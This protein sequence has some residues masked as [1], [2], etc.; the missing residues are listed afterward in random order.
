MSD[1]MMQRTDQARFEQ[2][3]PFYVTSKLNAEDKAF[4]ES[5]SANNPEARKAIQFTEQLRHIVRNTGT[6]RNPNAALNRLLA[7]YKPRQRMSLI[8]RLLAKLRSLGISPPLAIAL[9]VI[10]GQGIGYAAHKMNWFGGASES[11]VSPAEAQLSV[12]IK[13]GADYGSLAVIIEKF[14]GRI[15]HSS[16]S[17]DVEKFFINV[18]DK[19]KI[20]GLIDALMDAGLIDTAAI[21]L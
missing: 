19:T 5:Y 18:I 8:K 7:D 16:V 13:K 12:N 21:L 15:V 17:V 2:L 3:L 14:G 1:D 11:I 9:L 4:V 20:Q 6:S 10:V